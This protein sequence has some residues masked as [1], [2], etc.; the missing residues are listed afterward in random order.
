MT[1]SDFMTY[2]H[3]NGYSIDKVQTYG[4]EGG[5]TAKSFW[6]FPNLPKVTIDEFIQ[7]V[8]EKFTNYYSSLF[9][10]DDCY[11]FTFLL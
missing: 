2:C 7:N 5:Y 8:E 10:F 3:A 4:F 1:D 6:V 11:M 9:C